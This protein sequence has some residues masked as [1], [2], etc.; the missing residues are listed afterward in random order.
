MIR[1]N[2]SGQEAPARNC[3]HGLHFTVTTLFS[4]LRAPLGSG[5]IHVSMLLSLYGRQ[6]YLRGAADFTHAARR[7]IRKHT[8]A[9]RRKLDSVWLQDTEEQG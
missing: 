7:K 6:I 2:C 9:I 8:L 4:I 1:E 5:V 3:L